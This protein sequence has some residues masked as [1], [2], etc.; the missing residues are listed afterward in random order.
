MTD[1]E[2][3]DA[4]EARALED[5]NNPTNQLGTDIDGIVQNAGHPS[6]GPDLLLALDNRPPN[7][8]FVDFIDFMRWLWKKVK[9][10]AQ[11]LWDKMF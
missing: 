5:W 9:E 8:D 2:L 4:I 7:I 11:W 6:I 3:K 10:F 1:A